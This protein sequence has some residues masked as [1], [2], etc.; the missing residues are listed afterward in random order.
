MDVFVSKIKFFLPLLL[1]LFAS[2]MLAEQFAPLPFTQDWFYTTPY[3]FYSIAVTLGIMFKRSRLVM[4]I[5][6]SV[7]AYSIIQFR[8]QTPLSQQHTFIQYCLLAFLYPVALNLIFLFKNSTLFSKQTLY[9]LAFLVLLTSWAYLTIEYYSELGLNHTVSTLLYSYQDLSTLPVI[10]ILYLLV[11]VG[12][13]AILYLNTGKQINNSIFTSLV[14]FTTTM[15][16]FDIT[17]ISSVLF[18]MDALLLIVSI[19]TYVRAMAYKDTLTGLSNR[20]A[21]DSDIQHLKKRYSVAMID[22]DHFKKFNDTYG[23]DAGDDVLRLVGS[24]LKQLGRK[25]RIYRYGGEEFTVIYKNM[26]SDETK[27]L[28][29]EIRESLSEYEMTLRN[30][31]TRPKNDKL[32]VLKRRGSNKSETVSVTVSIGVSDSNSDATTAV[33]VLKIA[34]KALYKAKKQGRNRVVTS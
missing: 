25:A 16:L 29:D 19:I 13:S 11:L 1:A 10:L 7:L 5:F 23:H 2:V 32:G 15:V 6:A 27:P 12:I 3:V 21:L 4:L 31:D 26:L 30:S 17:S 28:L 33:E 22:V 20:R 9:Y 8:L 18:S 24:R 34:D 14:L